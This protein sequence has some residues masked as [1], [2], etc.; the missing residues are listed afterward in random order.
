ME[1]DFFMDEVTIKYSNDYFMWRSDCNGG[2]SIIYEV[3]S[4]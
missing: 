2:D 1:L 3:V 4:K